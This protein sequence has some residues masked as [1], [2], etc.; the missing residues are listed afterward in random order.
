MLLCLQGNA[1]VNLPSGRLG[2]TA[3]HMACLHAHVDIVESLLELG[4]YV[5]LSKLWLALLPV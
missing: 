2:L 3:L 5:T 4:E 1:D